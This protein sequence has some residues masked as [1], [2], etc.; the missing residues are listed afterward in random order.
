MSFV[1]FL[2]VSLG[3]FALGYFTAVWLG[4]ASFSF[5]KAKQDTTS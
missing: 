4:F 3:N 1:L 5:G 2:F